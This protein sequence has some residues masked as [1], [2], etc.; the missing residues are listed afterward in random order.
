MLGHASWSW[1]K[2]ELEVGSRYGIQGYV[3]ILSTLAWS[4]IQRRD[5]I[6][7]Y[8]PMILYNFIIMEDGPIRDVI[9]HVPPLP[10]CS[11]HFSIYT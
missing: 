6:C 1:E 3:G 4:T 5:H 9:F 2:P 7:V 10:T 8:R 11:V